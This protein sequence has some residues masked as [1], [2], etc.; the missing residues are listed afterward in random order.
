MFS[1]TS[2]I[3]RHWFEAGVAEDRCWE[4][5]GTV[6]HL[7]CTDARCGEGAAKHSART[8]SWPAAD[9]LAGLREDGIRPEPA[10]L[11]GLSR[12]ALPDVAAPPWEQ[13]ERWS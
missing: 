12:L 5:H 7:Q 6:R 11:A 13:V 9:A 8:G 3:D 1:F 10:A 4:V 2:N